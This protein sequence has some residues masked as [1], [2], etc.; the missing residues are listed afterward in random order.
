MVASPGFR[1]KSKTCSST[2][3]EDSTESVPPIPTNDLKFSS[4]NDTDFQDLSPVQEGTNLREPSPDLEGA[5][6]G[7][8]DVESMP[9]LT[10]LLITVPALN[11]VMAK[12]QALMP[13]NTLQ[14]L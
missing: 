2:Q 4:I 1:A 3:R 8:F 13:L 14:P 11:T 7:W 10:A 5:S 12:V 9:P 6:R